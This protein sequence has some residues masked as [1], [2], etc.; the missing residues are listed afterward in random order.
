MKVDF[1]KISLSPVDGEL[2]VS[3][4]INQE[5]VEKCGIDGEMLKQRLNSP[6]T[7]LFVQQLLDVISEL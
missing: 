2:K 6:I 4:D 7:N 1:L 5:I 3:L